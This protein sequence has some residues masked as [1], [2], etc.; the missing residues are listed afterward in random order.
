LGGVAFSD[1]LKVLDGTERPEL[2]IFS[3]RA[4]DRTY[5]QEDPNDKDHHDKLVQK[6]IAE[7]KKSNNSLPTKPTATAEP[8]ATAHDDPIWNTTN[9]PEGGDAS[10]EDYFTTEEYKKDVIQE[11]MYALKLKNQ[12]FRRR[13]R[14]NSVSL[15]SKSRLEAPRRV[16]SQ[17]PLEEEIAVHRNQS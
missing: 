13:R 3:K 14:C 2:F 1:Y 5:L 10:P 17:Q 7:A 6:R 8:T 15:T 16:P 9:A 12:P 11:C 4:L